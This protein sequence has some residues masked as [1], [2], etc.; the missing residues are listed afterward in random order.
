MEPPPSLTPGPN[1]EVRCDM[2]ETPEVCAS[3]DV[4]AYLRSAPSMARANPF[5]RMVSTATLGFGDEVPERQDIRTAKVAH[6]AADIGE[7][8]PGSPGREQPLDHC[9]HFPTNVERLT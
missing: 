8:L 7:C 6:D 3:L 1:A 9:L 2:P 4:D 5:R